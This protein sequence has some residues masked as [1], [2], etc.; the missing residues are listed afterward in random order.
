MSEK[1][2]FRIGELASEFNISLRSLRFYEDRGL[3][4][5]GREGTTRIYSRKDRA[6][7]KLVLLFKALGFSLME[8]KQIIEVYDQPDGKR[9]QLELM[10][11]RLGEQQQFLR[12]QSEELEKALQLM[13][14]T[15]ASVNA[16]LE[17][18][19]HDTERL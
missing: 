8:A 13:D 16:K 18:P 6:R 11:T 3:L 7:L 14:Q 1:D 15:L 9:Q 17:A 5:P 2:T 19:D 4:N 12:E 10:R